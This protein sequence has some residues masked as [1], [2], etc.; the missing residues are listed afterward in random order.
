MMKIPNVIRNKF[1]KIKKGTCSFMAFSGHC[2]DSP[3]AISLELHK[4]APDIKQSWIVEEKYLKDVPAFAEK[5]I[6]DTKEAYKA[7]NPSGFIVDNIY[8]PFALSVFNTPKHRLLGFIYKLFAS[9]KGQKIYTTWHGNAFKKSG[10]DQIGNDIIDFYCGDM[11][12]FLSAKFTQEIFSHLTF[13]KAKIELLGT[14]RNDRLFNQTVED[15]K[16]E[17]G[18]PIDKKIVLY[19][20][21]FRNDGKDVEDKNV[22]RSG[23]DQLHMI[24]FDR[25][26]DSLT[27]KF[28]GDFVFVCRFHY[29]VSEMVDWADLKMK[30][31]DRVVNGNQCDDMTAYLKSADILI[32]DASSCMYDY[33]LQY[34]PCFL[35]FPDLSHYENEERGFYCPISD[36]PFARAEDFNAL[37]DSILSFDEVKY[38]DDL[39]RMFK[40]MG[41]VDDGNSTQRIVKYILDEQKYRKKENSRV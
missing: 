26:F 28:G 5:Y 29:H 18:L 36:L 21:T 15:A 31:G 34:K 27:K 2:S 39:N 12:M 8:G 3:L 19:A 13:G 33:S 25:L 4:Q 38:R 7:I 22:Y 32:T 10:R 9:K 16:K 14:P 40:E 23:I 11:T 35:F 37:V 6:I 17:C 41:F 1:V 20:P 24:D 30:Y